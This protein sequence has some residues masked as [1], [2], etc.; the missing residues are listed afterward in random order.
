MG[1]TMKKRL[2]TTISTLAALL[3]FASGT[4]IAQQQSDYQLLQDFRADY[5]EITDRIQD[6]ETSEDISEIA[7]RIEE[8]EADYSGHESL[9]NS[10]IWPDTFE[11]RLNIL[12]TSLAG[13]ERDFRTIEEL[14]ERIAELESDIEEY[15]S[16][17]GQLDEDSEALRERLER[18]TASERRLSGLVS[19][20]RQN[21]EAR[22]TF[23]SGFLENLLNRYQAMDSQTQSEI[24]E[25]SERLEDD[26]IELLR[27]IIS[28]YIN[29]ADRETGLD[30]GDYLRMRAQHA[31]FN[32]VWDQV[33]ENMSNAYAA[34]A[35]VQARQEITD[36]LS[37]WQASID[38]KLWNALSTSFNQNGIE[39]P[40]FTSADAFRNALNQFVDDAS[41]IA[42]DQNDE[43]D[44][45]LFQSFN[46]FWNGTVKADWGQ[47]LIV[48]NV[49]SEGDIAEI[50][51]KVADWARDAEPVSNLMFILFLISLAVIIGLIVLL[52]TKKS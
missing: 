17:I 10:A 22:D 18:A 11:D 19:Q 37:A 15:R 6:A 38:N 26:P 34:D 49:L 39:L 43:A 20:Y 8:L 31:D 1:I 29:Q 23:V 33:G 41:A 12:R 44:L 45:Q 40:A 42:R 35:P 27:T 4:V 51:I 2:T 21:I 13:S 28:E 46:D 9:I 5:N 32:S 47:Y 52:V 30:A 7:D 16:Q 14:N 24:A 25:A 36:L 3:L 50:D 48:G